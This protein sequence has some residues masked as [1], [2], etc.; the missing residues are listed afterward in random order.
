MP[1]CWRDNARCSQYRQCTKLVAG[2][3]GPESRESRDLGFGMRRGGLELGSLAGEGQSQ[4]RALPIRFFGIA[5]VMGVM[6]GP[7]IAALTQA[8]VLP[9]VRLNSTSWWLAPFGKGLGTP[10]AGSESLR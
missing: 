3:I 7:K 4:A 1:D 5:F 6:S 8:R 2:A 10:P 9:R